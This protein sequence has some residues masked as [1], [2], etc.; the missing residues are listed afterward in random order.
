MMDQYDDWMMS[1]EATKFSEQTLSVSHRRKLLAK[2]CG[3]CYDELER[4]RC[5]LEAA[6]REES[7]FYRAFLNT[8]CLVTADGTGD[9]QIQVLEKLQASKPGLK[10]DTVVQAR[11]REQKFY[12]ISRQRR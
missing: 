4:K 1:G 7:I 3:Q 10:I 12:H 8:G 2:W 11:Q 9:D 5:A 6:G